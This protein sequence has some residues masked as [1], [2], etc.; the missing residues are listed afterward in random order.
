MKHNDFG[1]WA[2]PEFLS[3]S[4]WADRYR[5]L[6]RDYAADPGPYESARTPYIREIQDAFAIP[7]VR[8]IVIVKAARVGGTEAANNMLGYSI[9]HSPGPTLYVYPTENDARDEAKTRVSRFIEGSP[10][11]KAHVPNIGWWKGD[12][13]NLDRMTIWMAWAAAPGTLTRRTIRNLFIDELDNCNHQV[14][15]LGDTLSLA[16]KRITTYVSRARVVVVTSPTTDVAAAW[17]AYGESD[18]RRF[19]V[20]CPRC[21]VFQV[22]VFERLKIPEGVRDPERVENEGLAWYQCATCNAKIYEPEKSWMLARGVWIPNGR[23]IVESLP[24][25]SADVVARAALT[26]GERWRPQIDGEAKT[27]RNIGFHI[28]GLL[29]PW[30][31]W[32]DVMSEFLRSK[33]HPERLRVFVN[34]VLGEP[35]KDTV[36]DVASERVQLLTTNAYPRLVVPKKAEILIVAADVQK[37]HLYYIVRAWGPNRESWLIDEG[38]LSDLDELLMICVRAYEVQ[39]TKDEKLSAKWA[40]VDSKY[41]TAE[42]YTFATKYHGI[43]PVTGVQKAAVPVRPRPIEYVSDDSGRVESVDGLVVDTNYYKS[44]FMRMMRTSA[45]A[46]ED[47]LEGTWHLHRQVSGAYCEQVRAEQQVWKTVKRNHVKTRILV[48]EPRT[49]HAPNHFLDC[50][51]M[52]LALADTK[53]ILALRETDIKAA[54]ETKPQTKDEEPTT[55]GYRIRRY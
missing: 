46:F 29:S 19:H 2:A 9:D 5:R 8:R 50:E 27:T 28:G 11:L 10:K 25:E 1:W 32:S 17:T 55:A 49:Q 20:P 4:D 31:T 6:Q 30:R 34:Q 52:G 23:N 53:G 21:G 51:M 33:D 48:W 13:L 3:V 26:G 16:E 54:K 14:G 18:Q 24:I 42:I 36:D 7:G 39:D 12:E 40:A 15:A 47:G 43:Y 44:M 22:L 35:W 37:D 38:T 41:R 45:R